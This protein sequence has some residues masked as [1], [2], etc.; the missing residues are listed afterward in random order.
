MCKVAS[1]LY[2]GK[3]CSQTSLPTT[4]PIPPPPPQHSH[5]YHASVEGVGLKA[6]P[7][8]LPQVEVSPGPS[9]VGILRTWQPTMGTQRLLLCR[10]AEGLHVGQNGPHIHAL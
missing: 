5:T 9:P 10:Q 8:L 4:S 3:D 2:A 6:L 7:V 1:A